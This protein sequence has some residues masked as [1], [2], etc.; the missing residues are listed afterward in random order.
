MKTVKNI[1]K[2]NSI[3]N[4]YFIKPFEI[5]PSFTSFIDTWI[6]A[7]KVCRQIE[8]VSDTKLLQSLSEKIKLG[9]ISFSKWKSKEAFIKSNLENT[10]LK[11]H[12]E[13]NGN[14]IKSAAHY[15]YK[16]IREGSNNLNKNNKSIAKVTLFETGLT[17]EAEVL[18]KWNTLEGNEND[19]LSSYLFKAIYKN[20]KY[21][22]IGLV[23]LNGN[24]KI[25]VNGHNVNFDGN[26]GIK[27]YTMHFK[28]VKN[29]N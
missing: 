25:T 2:I 4:Y 20:S 24:P 18:K 16:L 28:I 7:N 22:Y 3:E 14:G 6:V 23:Y 5:E 29:I 10:V 12:N 1:K 21:R 19:I 13:I 15:L 27:N 8:E 17:D 9:Y 26:N 11:Y